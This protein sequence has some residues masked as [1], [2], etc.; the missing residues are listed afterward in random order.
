[1]GS[2]ASFVRRSLMSVNVS[3][4]LLKLL[5]VLK[6]TVQNVTST[7]EDVGSGK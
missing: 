1:M 6:H 2:L 5:T 3:Q 4:H 7:L